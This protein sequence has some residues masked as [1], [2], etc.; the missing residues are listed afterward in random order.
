MALFTQIPTKPAAP[1]VAAPV[2]NTLGFVQAPAATV[3]A[4]APAQ[5]ATTT[6]TTQTGTNAT[7]TNTAQQQANTNTAKPVTQVMSEQVNNPSIPKEGMMTATP[8]TVNQNEMM[9]GQG[10]QIAGVQVAQPTPIQAVQLAPAQTAQAA[11]VNAQEA[12]AGINPNAGTYQATTVSGQTP[13]ATAQQG[14]VNELATVQGQLKQLYSELSPGQIP[15]WAKG[16]VTSANEA[17]AARNMGRTTVGTTAIAAAIQERAIN[18]AAQ[19]AATY[20]QM[21]LTNLNNRQQTEFVNIQLKQ[22]SLLSD[23][24]AMNVASQ[25]NASSTAQVQQFMASM[26]AQIKTQNADR[27]TA[28]SQFNA[29]Q[30]NAFEQAQAALDDGVNK[31]NKEMETQI[32][33]FNANLE[34]QR[35]TFNATNAFAIEQSN[36]LWRRSVN[37]ANTAATNAA[38]QTNAQNAFN[39]S[40]TALNNLW[41][42]YRDEAAWL[43]TASE[44]EKNR[45]FQLA[46]LANQRDFAQDQQG[47]VLAQF[48]GKYAENLLK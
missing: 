40:S 15:E 21:D 48:A 35:Q 2:R 47:N 42:Q 27:V 10:S 24:A 20:F 6:A 14:T 29:T 32:S 8:I 31:F 46:Y 25:F 3:A 23:Q 9:A 5:T 30:K 44:N 43:F 45:Q 37:T 33:T 41:Q 4:P 28:V 17:M 34:A 11:E 13:Q 38:N 12:V 1:V 39:L 16:A 22:Q 18:I 19:D 26:V 7:N 36:V